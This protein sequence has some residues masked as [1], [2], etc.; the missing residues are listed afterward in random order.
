MSNEELAALVQAGERERLVELWGQTRRLVLKQANRWA[1]YRSGGAELEDLEQA[2]FIAVLRAADS[3]DPAAGCKFSSWLQPFVLDEFTKATGRRSARQAHDPLNGA[4]S[5]DVPACPDEENSSPLGE[6][7][8]DKRAEDA[9][10]DVE[11]REDLRRLH[12]QLM[13]ALD[14]LP[15]YPRAAVMAQY[16]GGGAGGGA[17]RKPPAGI[18]EAAAP[19]HIPPLGG[20]PIASQNHRRLGFCPGSC[21][22]GA[23]G[24]S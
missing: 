20:V 13:E 4:A 7:M 19:Q 24:I 18:A 10:A 22:A 11:R 15:P 12:A 16:W 23:V 8:P 5:L 9:F 6:L 1:V 17:P 21:Y 14:T 3:F 2:G